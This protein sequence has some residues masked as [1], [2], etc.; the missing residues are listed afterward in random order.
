M[1]END[2]QLQQSRDYWDAEAASFDDQPDHGLR[3]PVIRAA[4]EMLLRKSLPPSGGSVLDIGCGTGSLSVVM[5]SLG[6]QVT[7]IDFSPEMISRAEAKAKASQQSIKFQVMD[8][9]FPQFPPEQFDA[10]VCRHLLWALPE[11]DQVL[12]RWEPL[13]K[14][15]GRLLLIEG[16]WHTGAG[17][18]A[19]QVIDALPK[20][21]PW[22]SVEN[23]S[24]Q[25]DLWG[26]TVADNRYAITTIVDRSQRPWRVKIL[27]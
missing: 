13:L 4:W 19:M 11:L 26:G 6:Y 8:A 9:A 18:L 22:S 12:Q 21:F 17:L 20:S 2:Q 15:G 1:S 10:I 16:Y 14:L 23:L 27:K 24:D 5:A 25:A 7:G 3:D